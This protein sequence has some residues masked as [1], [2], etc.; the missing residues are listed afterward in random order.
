MDLGASEVRTISKTLAVMGLFAQWD[1]YALGIGDIRLHSALNEA[2]YAEIPLVTS[3]ADELSGI[4]VT[5]ASPETFA[6]AHIERN[7]LLTKLRF[8]TLQRPDGGY[9]IKVSSKDAIRE[10]FLDFMV[11]VHWPQGRLQREFTVLLDPPDSFHEAN[12]TDNELPETESYEP[13]PRQPA[14]SP[15]PLAS[16]R[17]R[18]PSPGRETKDSAVKPAETNES[19]VTGTQYG[20][21]GRNE[22][23]WGIAS[24]FQHPSTSQRQ[25]LAAI[26]K[27]NPRAFFKSSIDALKAGATI[28]IPDQASVVRLAD[29]AGIPHPS[30]NAVNAKAKTQVEPVLAETNEGTGTQGQLQ[31]LAPSESKS[32]AEAA[33]TGK[34]G[35]PGKSKEDLAL[36]L[37]DTAKQ[38]N[39]N[40]RKRLADLEQQLSSV[41]RLLILKDE[42]IASLQSQQK[43]AVKQGLQTAPL[44]TV[45]PSAPPSLTAVPP[46]TSQEPAKTQTAA[47]QLPVSPQVVPAPPT[48][49]AVRP[50]LPPD[51]TLKPAEAARPKP[52]PRVVAPPSVQ[53]KPAESAQPGK[54]A[55][56]L[57]EVLD[58]PYYLI[59]GATGLL[60]LALLWQFKRR[61]SAMIDNPESILTLTDR[62]KTLQPN[63][64][65]EPVN[66][67]SNVSEPSPAFRSSFLSEF[68]PSDFNALGGE[69]EEVDPL[70][71]ADVYLAY[72]RYK[73]AEDL[74]LNAIG[75][76]PERDDY[77]L[78]LLEIHYATENAQAFEQ[79]ANELALTHRE[80]KP[81]FWE[82][83]AEMGREMCPG[84]PFFMGNKPSGAGSITL[85]KSLPAKDQK[86]DA[87]EDIYLFSQEDGVE[88]YAY[89]M[90]PPTEEKNN[91]KGLDVDPEEDVAYDFFPSKGN[92]DK[93]SKKPEDEINI[94]DV[95]NVIPHDKAETYPADE[96]I[97]IPG[98][99]MEEMLAKL[100]A[101]SES[102]S[103]HPHS[104]EKGQ[105]TG[106]QEDLIM[107]GGQ[108][109]TDDTEETYRFQEDDT[110]SIEA[111]EETDE[112]GSKLDLARAYFDLGDAGAARALLQHVARLGNSEQKEEA[113][114]LLEKLDSKE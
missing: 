48:M 6:R 8:T 83:V 20:P 50:T 99:S 39:E 37:A 34:R 113:N 103:L 11:E 76:N 64:V 31:L 79:C 90:P 52:P 2:L 23:L 62:E 70:S 95:Q 49:P 22:T 60:L 75:Q 66:V 45:P 104:V 42:Q 96:E 92:G 65:P 94:P 44:A 33:T 16:T 107:D 41:Q 81:E 46:P 30:R 111:L 88:S 112:M 17:A 106:N 53:P 5:L 55:G 72:G 61:R 14:L 93:L 97:D 18:T 29:A 56:I 67:M 63:P 82:K 35:K 7:Y 91:V 86:A 59:G 26:Y 4:R 47:A 77:S 108:M 32:L 109:K 25:M 9:V 89:S 102:E 19:P 110:A 80:S 78:K 101:L 12:A 71:E 100:G 85:D 10:P 13:A 1:A 43:P 69:M 15:P 74:I 73:Q 51:T 24:K 36:E 28:T 98:E 105:Q 57:A 21:V 3:D 68:T 58:R 87:E 38:E 54:E 40:Y 114:S 27:A 84:N